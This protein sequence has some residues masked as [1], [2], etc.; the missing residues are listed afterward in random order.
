[1]GRLKDIAMIIKQ[2]SIFL[3]NKTGRLVE[4][5]SAL[6]EVKI[7]IKAITIAD[8]SEFGILRILVSRPEEALSLLRNRG[9]SVNLTE[10]LAIATPVEAGSFAKALR[11][12]SDENI[13]I[14]Y[15][16]GFSIG[17]KA[18][19]IIRTDDISRASS[20]IRNSRMELLNATELNQL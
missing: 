7:D 20:V 6:G 2:L 13:G 4:V 11:I 18:A 9:F 17:A 16:Y 8:T 19:I 10:V 3:E 15:M 1:M 5:L 12:L 14:E